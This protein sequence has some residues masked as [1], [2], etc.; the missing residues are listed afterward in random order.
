M[1]GTA[2]ETRN[3]QTPAARDAAPPDAQTPTVIDVEAH[4]ITQDRPSRAAVLVDRGLALLSSLA[5]LALLWVQNREEQAQRITPRQRT[6]TTPTSTSTERS[7]VGSG[8]GRRQR[9]RHRG[10]THT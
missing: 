1:T 9:R 10:R 4:P 7:A 5:R 8:G 6:P 3:E 2:I